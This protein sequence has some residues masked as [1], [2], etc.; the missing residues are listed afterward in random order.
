MNYKEYFNAFVDIDNL[1]EASIVWVK[2]DI[3]RL[4]NY[5]Q[6]IRLSEKHIEKIKTQLKE[7]EK[8]IDYCL[9]ETVMHSYD[10]D[11]LREYK[12]KYTRDK[13]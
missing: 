7:A 1:K 4:E 11:K 8:V 5:E 10:K 6:N 12:A 2:E 13:G 3:R 9:T